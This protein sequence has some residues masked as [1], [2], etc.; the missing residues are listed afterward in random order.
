M[1]KGKV[2]WFNDA[3]GYGWGT[4][5]SN[6]IKATTCSFTSPPFK[7]RDSRPWRRVKKWSSM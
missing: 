1:Q 5:L 2:K 6:R 3:K 4:A 7:P